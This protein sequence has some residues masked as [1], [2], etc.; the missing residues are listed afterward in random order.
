MAPFANVCTEKLA[1]EIA[2]IRRLAHL[3]TPNIA[4]RTFLEEW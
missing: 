1:D 4:H 2:S 3:V